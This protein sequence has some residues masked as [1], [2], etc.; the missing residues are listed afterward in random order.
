MQA[1][2]LEGIFLDPNF[3]FI[4]LTILVTIVN[5]LIGVSL[6]PQDKRKKGLKVHRLTYYAVVICY[7]MF[8]WVSHSV[9]KN[10]WLN[11]AVLTYFLFVI[12][13]TRRINITLHAVLAS[14]G[15]VLLVGVASFSVL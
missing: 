3:I 12:P 9:T 7:S 2:T 5:I 4:F 13:I 10:S 15:L 11:Y 8:L 14:V 6:L 1:A